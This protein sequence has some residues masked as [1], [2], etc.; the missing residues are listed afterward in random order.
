LPGRTAANADLR[1]DRD[2]ATGELLTFT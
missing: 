1:S 2:L